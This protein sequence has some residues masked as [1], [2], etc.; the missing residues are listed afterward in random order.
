M[1]LLSSI[2]FFASELKCK[3][4]ADDQLVDVDM[5]AQKM[6][7]QQF[8]GIF[9]LK[10]NMYLKNLFLLLS[11]QLALDPE[12]MANQVLPTVKCFLLLFIK[13]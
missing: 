11:E 12:L 3:V 4:L 10:M 9:N 6:A 5:N 1:S 8:G 2:E 13:G 7:H